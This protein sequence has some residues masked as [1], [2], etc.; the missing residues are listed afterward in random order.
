MRLYKNCR[1]KQVETYIIFINWKTLYFKD[2]N[3]PNLICR[4]N[5]IPNKI[6]EENT[7]KLS[8]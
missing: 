8:D 7:T 2:V 6:I 1:T 3:S 4:V 5:G